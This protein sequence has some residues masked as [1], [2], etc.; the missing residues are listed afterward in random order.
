ML[1]EQRLN[2]IEILFNKTISSIKYSWA[3]SKGK[4]EFFYVVI[5]ALSV[6][7]S[8]EINKYHRMHNQLNCA[9]EIVY[10][11]ILFLSIKRLMFSNIDFQ[12]RTY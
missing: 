7:T 8:I 1:R 2:S 5:I 9:R 11:L 3:P 4:L 12:V 10:C 6:S